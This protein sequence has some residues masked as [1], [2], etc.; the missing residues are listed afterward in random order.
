MCNPVIPREDRL[1][2]CGNEIQSLKHCL[3]N[4][5]LLE[6]TYERYNMTSVVEAFNNPMIVTI[7]LEIEKIFKI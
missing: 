6:D 5:P 2:Q 7:L 4:C 1:C 3:T